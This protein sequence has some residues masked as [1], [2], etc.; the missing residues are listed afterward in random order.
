MDRSEKLQLL[1][2]K[3][4]EKKMGR[5]TKT[6]KEK[7]FKQSLEQVGIDPEKFK[8]DLKDLKDQGGFTINQ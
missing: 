1:K 7:V 3:I 2:Q 8:Q 4:L 6:N 5:Y